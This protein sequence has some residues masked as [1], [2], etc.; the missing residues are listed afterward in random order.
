MKNKLTE[1]LIKNLKP[2]IKEYFVWDSELKGFGVRVYTSGN[3]TD[4]DAAFR[5]LASNES[6]GKPYLDKEL[7]PRRDAEAELLASHHDK[8][9]YIEPA[10]AKQMEV[11]SK[12]IQSS[13][14]K[15]KKK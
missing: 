12:K 7:Q 15:S 11:S 8:E 1:N 6:V 13:T 10:L 9:N 14:F 2:D 5:E 4:L 3:K